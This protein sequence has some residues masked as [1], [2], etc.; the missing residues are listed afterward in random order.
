[1][2]GV[3]MERW[4]WKKTLS[5]LYKQGEER[6]KIESKVLELA[7]ERGDENSNGGTTVV[8]LGMSGSQK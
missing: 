4:A 1:M 3:Q 2:N 7:A 5:K 6:L 8:L